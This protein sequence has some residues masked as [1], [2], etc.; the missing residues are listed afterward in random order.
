MSWLS[1]GDNDYWGHDLRGGD[2]YQNHCP[3]CGRKTDE[4]ELCDRCESIEPAEIRMCHSCQLP[5]P[6]T[7]YNETHDCCEYCL[8]DRAEK[9]TQ[10][11]I[12]RIK[13]L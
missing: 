10:K 13:T 4:E 12:N 7:E 8:E 5:V 11:F 2:R 3:V 6:A 9:F 1:P